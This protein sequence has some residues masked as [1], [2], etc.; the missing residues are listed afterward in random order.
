VPPPWDWP[1]GC[2]FAPRC[3]FAID[4]CSAGKVRLVDGVRCIRADELKLALER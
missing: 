3:G 4:Q 2:R 1:R